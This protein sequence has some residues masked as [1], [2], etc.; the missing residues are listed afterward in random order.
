[1]S[2]EHRHHGGDLA[3]LLAGIR[4]VV[5]DFDGPVCK[6]FADV[7]AADVAAQ[8]HDLLV[9]QGAEV[10]ADIAGEG[11]PIALLRFTGQLDADAQKRIEETLT[12]AELRA[13]A[14]A[15]P[16]RYA[17]DLLRACRST[18][19]RVAIVSNNSRAA[20]QTYLARRRLGDLIDTVSARSEAN[21]EWLKPSPHLVSQALA[22]LN[23]TADLAIMIGDSTTDITSARLA[24]I[25]SIGYANKA[26]KFERLLDAGADAATT[27]LMM[28][29]RAVATST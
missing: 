20:I 14:T 19:R 9:A 27:S 2:R 17:E 3:A 6:V 4:Y 29:A 13:I 11:D 23:A 16:T 12:R 5:L 15:A 21:P 18:D 8:I 25:R 1:L 10:P 28:I 24:G 7:P 22:Q 26:G